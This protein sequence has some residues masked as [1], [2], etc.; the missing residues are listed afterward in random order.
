M[1]QEIITTPAYETWDG[2]FLNKLQNHVFESFI[3]NQN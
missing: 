3:V 2:L 1:S